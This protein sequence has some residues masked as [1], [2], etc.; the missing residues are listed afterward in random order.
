[1]NINTALEAG[2][3]CST[4]VGDHLQCTKNSYIEFMYKE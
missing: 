2:Q 3:H 4:T 1:M